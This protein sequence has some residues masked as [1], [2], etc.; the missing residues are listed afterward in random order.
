MKRT[1][2][3]YTGSKVILFGEHFVV[4]KSAAIAIPFTSCGVE[5]LIE[6]FRTDY[7]V[8]SL[9]TGELTQSPEIFSG[10]KELIINTKILLGITNGLHF[11]I[12]SSIPL[13]RG[14]GS[15]AA[16]SIGII[17]ALY[18]YA[19]EDVNHEQLK[20]LA[21]QAENVHHQNASGIDIETILSTSPILF[22]RGS[23]S[24]E[25]RSKIKGTLLLVDSQILGSTKEAVSSV[26]DFF[27]TNPVKKELILFKYS[28]VIEKALEAF[29]T[30]NINLLGEAMNENQ[31]L[32]KE[33]HVSHP[34]ID[35]L[36]DYALSKNV[37]GAK[38]TGGGLGGCFLVLSDDSDITN[39]LKTY[40]EN[41]GLVVRILEME[42]NN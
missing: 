22:Q 16:I 5:V 13:Q 37:L 14:M 4:F 1:G 27:E 10:L 3:S 29:E 40:Y 23:Q 21:Q 20:N 6:D 42:G 31:E 24:I 33:I 35:S 17:K 25:I 2:S 30:G 32:L 38:I 36:I 26:A 39:R 9:Y 19:L 7:V 15:S 28:N 11:T 8:S 12:N 34:K 18:S 41:E